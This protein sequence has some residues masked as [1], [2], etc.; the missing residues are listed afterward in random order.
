MTTRVDA[1]ER[2]AFLELLAA[3]SLAVRSHCFTLAGRRAGTLIKS[4]DKLSVY[5]TRHHFEI[6]FHSVTART[7][8]MIHLVQLIVMTA[9]HFLLQLDGLGTFTGKLLAQHFIFVLLI[10]SY[11][12]LAI[13][14]W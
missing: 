8:E 1:S 13:L 14:N 4:S 12:G 11:D 7:R 2:G 10:R 5:Y 3:Q 9:E 6:E